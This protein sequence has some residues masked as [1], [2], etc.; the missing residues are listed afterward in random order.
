VDFQPFGWWLGWGKSNRG[1]SPIVFGPRTLGRTWGTR[2][3]SF[4]SVRA[5]TLDVVFGAEEV[6]EQGHHEEDCDDGG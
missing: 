3:I 1:A 5:L 6:D 4:G 2:P